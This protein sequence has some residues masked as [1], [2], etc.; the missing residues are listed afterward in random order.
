MPHM[1]LLRKLKYIR[2]LKATFKKWME[3]YLKGREMRAEVED[4]KSE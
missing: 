2:G 1:G 4:E 3:D